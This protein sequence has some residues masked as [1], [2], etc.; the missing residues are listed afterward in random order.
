MKISKVIAALPDPLEPDAIY[1][2]RA[3]AGF[4]LYVVDATGSTAHRLNSA[5][6]LANARGSRDTLGE[7]IAT[8]S[9]FASPN[10]GGF[11]VGRYYDN[12]F[13][14][15]A[16]STLAGAAGRIDLAP[17][18]TSIPLRINQIGVAVSTPVA[19]AQGKCLIYSSDANG[20]PDALEFVGGSALDFAT[21]GYK[22]HAVDFTFDNG[23]QYWLGVWQSSTAT[24]RTI[25]TTSAANLGLNSVT[26]TSYS[27][28]LR[29]IVAFADP[30]PDPWAFADSEL[31]AGIT[32][33]S[34]RMRAAALA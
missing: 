16:A 26:G 33:P 28:V 18:Y 12:A 2:V 21:T 24:L 20:W 11:V 9:N 7:R 30:A 34:I 6:E 3:G 13:H 27:T 22:S 17:F 14:G 4:D 31:T 23:R 8:I 1:A 25:A 29:R 32:P 19:A 5:L 15:A 10:A